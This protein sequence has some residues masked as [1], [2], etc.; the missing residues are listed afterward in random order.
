M[1]KSEIAARMVRVVERKRLERAIYVAAE[2][3]RQ[4]TPFSP[5]WDAAVGAVE[6]LERDLLR[7]SQ[8]ELTRPPAKHSA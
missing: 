4:E 7:L 1:D 2:R 6:D 8:S 5:S 3:A